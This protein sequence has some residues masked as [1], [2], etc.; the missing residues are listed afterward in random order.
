MCKSTDNTDIVP[1][2]NAVEMSSGD[3]EKKKGFYDS[4]TE[5]SEVET[6]IHYKAL[7]AA[8]LGFFGDSYTL[9]SIGAAMPYIK[10]VYTLTDKETGIMDSLALWGAVAGQLTFGY[11]ADKVGRR[12]LYLLTGLLILIGEIGACLS[13]TTST[14]PIWGMI[15]IFRVITGFGVG[16]EYPLSASVA[17]ESCPARK[18]G[19]LMALV[20]ATQPL[21]ATIGAA[22]PL[23]L[24]AAGV[25]SQIIWRVTVG[26]ALVPVGTSLILRYLMEES[27]SFKRAHAHEIQEEHHMALIEESAN[28]TST[29]GHHLGRFAKFSIEM[30]TLAKV[31]GRDVAGTALT[32][33]LFDIVTYGNGLASSKVASAFGIGSKTAKA[34]WHL[35]FNA[36]GV[37]SGFAAAL[38]LDRW[39]RVNIMGA[40]FC[41]LTVL[42][43]VLG[44]AYNPLVSHHTG[45]YIMAVLYGLT[46]MFSFYGPGSM[47]YVIPGEYFA[48][49]RKAKL[50]GFSAASGKVGAAISTYAFQ[51]L[52]AQT[53]FFISFVVALLGAIASF[54]LVP[55]Y[56]VEEVTS[57]Q[58]RKEEAYDKQREALSAKYVGANTNVQTA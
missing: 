21:G 13:Q 22:L 46:N 27:K 31:Y 52:G 4:E 29:H 5:I 26:F 57:I 39:G 16:G 23:I 19:K 55:R 48:S 47:T 30:Q 25:S 7:F 10:D 28:K 51:V 38:T 56:S 1:S 33:F 18:R 43:V 41:V 24:E 20:F 49:A 50:H 3:W 44:A 17:A 15:A 35:A 37:P 32:W 9:F 58:F 45:N 14:M 34:Q 53:V 36:M 12:S 42:Y 11:M 40:S 8:M 6:D 54:T 2:N